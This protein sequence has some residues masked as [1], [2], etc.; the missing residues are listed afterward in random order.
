MYNEIIKFNVSLLKILMNIKLYKDIKTI[1]KICKTISR[2]NY[3]KTQMIS[4]QCERSIVQF[5]E[6]FNVM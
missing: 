6:M 5:S 1:T 4:Q 2:I 3:L